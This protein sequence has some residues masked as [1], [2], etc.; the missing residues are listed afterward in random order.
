MWLELAGGADAALEGGGQ[1]SGD[2]VGVACQPVQCADTST[3]GA[4]SASPA[5]VSTLIVLN[6]SRCARGSPAKRSGE[7]SHRC[8]QYPIA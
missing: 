7:V 5:Q 4:R 3:L 2:G 6:V 1:A 8:V